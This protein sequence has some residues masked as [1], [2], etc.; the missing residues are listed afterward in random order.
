M[1]KLLI[2]SAALAMV[3]GSAQA[4][5]S[6]TVYGL[7]DA[8]YATSNIDHGA[9]AVTDQ[10]MVG[11]ID[12]G[13]G[14]G[15]LSGSRLGFRGTED[16]GGGLKANFVLETAI[17]YSTGEAATTSPN[18]TTS[19]SPNASMFGNT[20]QAFAGLSGNFGEIRIG[21]MHS[22]AK[23]MTEAIDPNAGIAMIGVFQQSGLQATRPA[24]TITYTTPVM[25]GFSAAAQYVEGETTTN[26][27]T[28]KDN[29]AQSYALR[30]RAGALDLVGSTETRKNASYAAAGR[31]LVALS[32]GSVLTFDTALATVIDKVKHDA[33]GAS[34]T[35]AGVKL[36]ALQTKLKMSDVTAADNVEISSTLLG[37]TFNVGK[38]KVTASYSTG[39]IE[40]ANTKTYDL[41][42]YQFVAQY[43]LSKRTNVYA[44]I[45]EA[46]YDSPSANS[47]VKINQMAVGMRHSF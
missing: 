10:K 22:L 14:T 24:N 9:G 8:G 7:I 41:D 23:D 37:A 30:Y 5:S 31:E 29:Y 38:V 4:Q 36:A 44:A 11:G 3:A 12:S 33:V 27:A 1:K 42:G 20:R 47:D 39:D 26:A 28:P 45:T 46:K 34:Y 32:S 40:R 6:V 16:L 18:N 25:N 43:D 15:S 35:V 19:L 17:K 13:N 21:T 2:A